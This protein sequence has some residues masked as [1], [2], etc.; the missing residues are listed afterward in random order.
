MDTSMPNRPFSAPQLEPASQELFEALAKLKKSAANYVNLSRLKLALQGVEG[1]QKAPVRVAVL[2]L[3]GSQE[4]ACRLVK[5]L[6][7]DPLSDEVPWEKQLDGLKSNDGR[8]LLIRYGD[9][10]LLQRSLL[11]TLSVP[12]PFLKTHNL[13]ILISNLHVGASPYDKVSTPRTTSLED[14]ILVPSLDTPAS[15]TGRFSV[16]T[17]PVHKA[18]LFVKG[19]QGAVMYGRFTAS[20][21]EGGSSENLIKVAVDL[22]APAIAPSGEIISDSPLINTVDVQLARSAIAKFRQS[23]ENATLY[24]QRWFLSGIPP[25]LEWLALGSAVG[26]AEKLKPAVRSLIISLL[27]ETEARINQEEYNQR[28]ATTTSRTLEP[29]RQAL[30]FA[31]TSWAERAHTELRDELDTAFSGKRWRRLAWWKLFWRVDDVGMIAEEVL[32]RRWLVE[33]E[34]E[35]IW[36]TGRIEESELVKAQFGPHPVGNP[37]APTAELNPESGL[38]RTFLDAPTLSP[39]SEL[40]ASNVSEDQA[41]LPALRPW[42]LDIP[43]ARSRLLTVT[44]PPLQSRAQSLLLQTISTSVLTSTLT[45]LLYLSSFSIYESGVVAALGLVWSLRRLQKK[46][47]AV[48]REWQEEVREEGRRAA[49]ETERTVWEI[50][51]TVGKE[52]K[53]LEGEGERQKARGDLLAIRE[54]LERLSG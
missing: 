20:Q 47:E 38:P 42:P 50:L 15:A 7:T 22:P 27:E 26:E 25:L 35:V 8:G 30:R 41:P 14:V 4:S 18:L 11:P 46:W 24:E 21:T 29:T 36:V 16:V 53:S 32:S 48:K 28:N 44:I 49:R 31:L 40:T 10:S 54:A 19:V 3:G 52:H 51:E 39:F 37:P 5:V 23:L 6:L 12:S 2:G 33:A 45:A 9:V 1:G 13:E 34:K 17:Y 43:I